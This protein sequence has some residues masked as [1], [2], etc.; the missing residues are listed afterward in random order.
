MCN[1]FCLFRLRI[2]PAHYLHLLL[3]ILQVTCLPSVNKASPS[4]RSS[5]IQQRS[6][7]QH[8]IVYSS[9]LVPHHPQAIPRLQPKLTVSSMLEEEKIQHCMQDQIK[10]KPTPVSTNNKSF[11][12]LGDL[13]GDMYVIG[14]PY[15]YSSD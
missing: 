6:I 9:R 2:V 12:F 8:S 4:L 3:Q 1:V 15:C 14:E 5:S 13:Y 7:A 11:N 10:L